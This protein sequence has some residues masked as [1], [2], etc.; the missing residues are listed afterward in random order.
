MVKNEIVLNK[1]LKMW[2]EQD[3]SDLET[4]FD[5]SIVYTECNGKQYQGLDQLKRWINDWNRNG[6]VIS[7]DITNA[8]SGYKKI[9]VE[10][11]FK[12]KYEDEIDCFNGSTVALFEYGKIVELREYKSIIQRTYPYGNI[13]N[14]KN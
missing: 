14:K 4:L 11:K 13:F 2:V 8:V 7:W 9:C 10:W 3:F 1:Y 12:Y 5:E 6:I